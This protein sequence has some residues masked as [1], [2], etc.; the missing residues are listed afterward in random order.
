MVLELLGAGAA[1]LVQGA[2]L[3]PLLMAFATGSANAVFQREGEV[4]VGVTYMTGTLVKLGQHLAAALAGRPRFIWASCL[5]LWLGLVAGAVAGSAA[6]PILGLGALWI[7]VAVA[8]LL[9]AGAA[10]RDRRGRHSM[11]KHSA[12]T[13]CVPD[14][15]PAPQCLRERSADA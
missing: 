10:A 11:I 15:V 9:L 7:A 14:P 4:S 6:F 5:L 12:A 3:A 8:A 2:T 1:T 13:R